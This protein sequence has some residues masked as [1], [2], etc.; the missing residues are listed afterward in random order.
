MATRRLD[1]VKILQSQFLRDLPIIIVGCA[2]V[3]F[4][5]SAFM[6]PNGLAAGGV[7]GLATIF[8][9][10]ASRQG[11]NLPV[12]FQTIVMNLLLLLFV[13]RSGGW[14]Y[15]IQTVT[16]FMLCGFFTDFFVPLVQ[17]FIIDDLLLAAIWGGVLGGIGYGLVF[18]RGANTG[19]VDIIGQAIYKVTSIPIGSAVMAMD[20]AICIASAPV[21]SIENA[22]YATVSM[23]INGLVVDWVI[24]G[25]NKKRCAWIISEEHAIIAN[26]IMYE[27]HRGCTELSARGVWSGEDRPMIMV[28]F[29]RKE[30]NYLKAIVAARDSEAIVVIADVGEVIGEGFKEIGA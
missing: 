6:V 15:L 14:K 18:S 29:D 12:G 19:G 27:M 10:I 20:V 30:I 26:D 24:D 4:S 9:E 8:S 25:G 21:F 17:P 7:T 22:M 23:I 2:I 16:G 13:I 3:G 5:V 1:M 28:I 11:I